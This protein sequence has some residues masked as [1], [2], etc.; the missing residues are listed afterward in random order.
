MSPDAEQPEADRPGLPHDQLKRLRLAETLVNV[1]RAVAATDSL[2]EIL[3]TLVALI[4][5]ETDADRGTLFLSDPTTGELYSRVAQGERAREIRFLDDHG[6]AGRVFHSGVGV[7]VNDAYD[8]PTFNRAIDEQTGY[9]TRNVACAPV[10]TTRGTIIGVAQV[11]NK[12][13]GDFTDDDLGLLEAMTA[14]ATVALMNS[15]YVETMEQR[16]AEE[17]EF[18]DL[19]SDITS[20]LDLGALL[21]R[22]IGEATRILHADRSTLFLNDDRTDELFSRVA[23]GD[24]VGEI[25]FPNNVGIAGAVFTTGETIN[26]PHAYADL[27]FNPSFDRQTGYFTRSILCVPVVTKAGDTIGVTQVLNK[28]GGP[29]TQD[30]EQRL[31]AFT[32]QVSIALQNAK[33]FDEMQ[34]MKNYSDAMLESMSNG[35]FTLDEAGRI[36]TCNA[37]GAR[38]LGLP[39]D[40]VVGHPVAEML[41]ASGSLVT[42]MIDRVAAG[43]PGEIALDVDLAI[44]SHTGESASVNVTVLPLV[45]AQQRTLGTMVVMEDISGE[46]RVRS[47]MARYMDPVLA[48]QLVRRN[49]DLL[50]GKSIE[51]TILFS[52]VRN[53]TTVAEELGPSGTVTLLNE[54]FTL[55]VDCIQAHGGM[56]DKFIGDA[57]MA[58]FGLPVAHDDDPDRG[59]KAAIA[60]IEA[61]FEW[62]ARRAADG[63]KPIDMGVGINTDLVVAGNIGSPKRMDFTVIGD[64][65]NL[66]SRLESACKTYRARILVS[67]H[68]HRRLRGVYRSR[69]ID[70]VI[71]KGKTEPVAVFEILDYHSDDSF[72]NVLDAIHAFRDGY[73]RYQRGE[74]DAAI[75]AFGA[76]LRANPADGV[77]ELYVDRCLQLR[78]DPPPS[79]TGVWSMT[80]K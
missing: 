74:W 18:L 4:A 16:Q 22:I 12:R 59:V 19:V 5:Q 64:G 56:L 9:H 63:R 77:A 57:I 61:L 32:A 41:R 20:E 29:F 25:R 51:T 69:E 2:D 7:I 49:E 68:T 45:N 15:R 33:L 46:K 48:D 28:R 67:E 30:D 34:T 38:M 1:S 76:G 71:V 55:M 60:M 39:E 31:R 52:D 10:R 79:W 62:N 13:G 78:A 47:T 21:Q 26:I 36:A 37:A 43:G 24:G 53:F 58:A 6:I 44:L 65:V 11:L 70:R 42:D 80:T 27:R 50:G 40:D 72:P 23:E 75:E 73:A 17:R 14:Q 35:V 3:A 66:A 54:Y 8:D